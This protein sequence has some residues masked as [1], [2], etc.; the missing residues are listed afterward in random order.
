[1]QL[2]IDGYKDQIPNV[3]LG[4]DKPS[5]HLGI[6][7][8]GVGYSS[9]MPALYYATAVLLTLGADVLRLDRIITTDAQIFKNCLTRKKRV[10]SRRMRWRF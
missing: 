10:G 9:Q 6:I 7:F 2:E 1:M 8:P 3:L 5:E 4:A